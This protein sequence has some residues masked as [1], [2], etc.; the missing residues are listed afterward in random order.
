M[1][2]LSLKKLDFHLTSLFLQVDVTPR[3]AL[4]IKGATRIPPGFF[5]DAP[6]E[7]NRETERDTQSRSQPFS[8]TLNLSGMLRK[9]D[10]SKIQLQEVKIP[11]VAGT[12]RNYHAGK[13][14]A[15]NSSRPPNTHTTQPNAATQSTPPALHVQQP[16]L[17]STAS[18]LLV[19]PGIMPTTETISSPRV[20]INGWRARLVG[21]LCCVPIQHT[22]GQP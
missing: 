21:W 5:D 9:P 15:P 16:P 17:T 7:A 2:L 6:R 18:P 1:F 11:Y 12:L 10:A 19:V 4:K 20:T 14:K 3:P 8:W 22:N 13:K